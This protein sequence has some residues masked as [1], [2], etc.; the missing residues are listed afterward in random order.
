M[1]AHSRCGAA[2]EPELG[3]DLCT[4]GAWAGLNYPGAGGGKKVKF[5]TGGY[6]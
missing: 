5:P 3:A 6:I 2:T 1:Q 4:H